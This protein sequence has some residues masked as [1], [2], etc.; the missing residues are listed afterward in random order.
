MKIWVEFPPFHLWEITLSA[1]A[2]RSAFYS[3]FTWDCD[4]FSAGIRRK[5]LKEAD[6]SDQ[7]ASFVSPWGKA[8]DHHKS[9]RVTCFGPYPE[10]ERKDAFQDRFSI[11]YRPLSLCLQ[12]QRIMSRLGIGLKTFSFIM[13]GTQ[14]LGHIS[15]PGINTGRLQTW[16][17]SHTLIHLSTHS[18]AWI[19]TLTASEAA[20]QTQLVC[21]T[22]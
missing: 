3:F 10:F 7:E 19:K 8:W 16:S 15:G 17:G 14:K 22:L 6:N 11:C 18:H 2:E 4:K 20:S 5:S 9:D 21:S 1:G 13:S 12:T